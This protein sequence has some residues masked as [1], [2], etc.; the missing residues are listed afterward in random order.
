MN[1]FL[2]DHKLSK[3]QVDDHQRDSIEEMERN[4][5]TSFGRPQESPSKPSIPRPLSG[6]RA[7]KQSNEIRESMHFFD[8][9]INDRVVDDE[10]EGVQSGVLGDSDQIG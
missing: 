8:N 2:N 10:L 9:T 3:Q 6:I 5:F 1:K 7:S 4:K